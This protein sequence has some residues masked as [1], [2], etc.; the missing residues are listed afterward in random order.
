MKEMMRE[1]PH[2]TAIS[3]YEFIT[4]AMAYCMTWDAE[5]SVPNSALSLVSRSFMSVLPKYPL[6]SSDSSSN[7]GIH[8]LKIGSLDKNVHKYKEVFVKEV[9][10]KIPT[11]DMISRY[12]KCLSGAGKRLRQFCPRPQRAQIQ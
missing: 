1:D 7:I 2:M 11:T 9:F 10:V 6:I 5:T 8:R 12:N 3:R 4:S